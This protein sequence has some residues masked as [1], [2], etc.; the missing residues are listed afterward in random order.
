MKTTYDI[1]L[2]YQILPHSHMIL[3]WDST[4]E[5]GPCC[6]TLCHT[7][8][9]HLLVTVN[10]IPLSSSFLC[11]WLRGREGKDLAGKRLLLVGSLSR[12]VHSWQCLVLRS[13][14]GRICY[15][16]SMKAVKDSRMRIPVLTIS[17]PSSSQE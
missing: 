4:V 5:S 8:R 16:A 9:I 10:R 6:C 13:L 14:E 17:W 1:S 12:S 2:Y 15:T 11:L 3:S 7:F